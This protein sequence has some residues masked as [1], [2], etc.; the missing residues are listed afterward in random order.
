MLIDVCEHTSAEL[1]GK[2]FPG[3]MADRTQSIAEATPMS[4]FV[5]GR[6]SVAILA[7]RFACTKIVPSGTAQPTVHAPSPLRSVAW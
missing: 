2:A 7:R 3:Y 6:A 5:S 1:S 4:E